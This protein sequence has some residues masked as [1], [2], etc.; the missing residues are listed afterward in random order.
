MADFLSLSRQ[1]AGVSTDASIPV[2]GKGRLV[3]TA[4]LT[5]PPAVSSVTLPPQNATAAAAGSASEATARAEPVPAA[6]AASEQQQPKPPQ[7]LCSALTA[8]VGGPNILQQRP[9]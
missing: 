4:G 6:T 2:T 7:A 9:A 1:P 5:D 3:T 8:K